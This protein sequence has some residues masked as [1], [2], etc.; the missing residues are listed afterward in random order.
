MH[1]SQDNRQR[2]SHGFNISPSLED[3]HTDTFNNKG[4]DITVR[5]GGEDMF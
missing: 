4:G 3:Q 5:D 2:H 1:Q